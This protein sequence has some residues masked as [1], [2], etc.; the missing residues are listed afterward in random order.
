MHLFTKIEDGFAHL[1]S[2]GVT[3]EVPIF[4][5]NNLIYAKYGGGYI[6]LRGRNGTSVAS[7]T[8]DDIHP[9]DGSFVENTFD[10]TYVPP[11]KAQ[12]KRKLAAA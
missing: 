8:W 5:L 12:T 3:R 11:R 6:R 10:L 2:K 4:E 1:Y 7:V 9:G